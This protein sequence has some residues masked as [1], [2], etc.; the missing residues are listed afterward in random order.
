MGQHVTLV[1]YVSGYMQ[2]YSQDARK[3][4][5]AFGGVVSDLG[6]TA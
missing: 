3:H 5:F 4:P 2:K 6:I 1:A